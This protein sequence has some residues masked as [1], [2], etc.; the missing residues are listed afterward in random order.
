MQAIQAQKP[1]IEALR[2]FGFFCYNFDYSWSRSFKLKIY[3][4]VACVVLFILFIVNSVIYI[5]TFNE[6]L[7]DGSKVTF[8]CHILEACAYQ[9]NGCVIIYTVAF[10]S[11]D[12]IQ[13]LKIFESVVNGLENLPFGKDDIMRSYRSL[14]QNTW[15]QIIATVSI[16]SSFLVTY[17]WLLRNQSLSHIIQTFNCLILTMYFMFIIA[18]SVNLVMTMLSLFNALND[19]LRV[20]I[21]TPGFYQKEIKLIMELHQKLSNSIH[22]FNESF[23]LAVF[24]AVVFVSGISTTQSYFAYVIISLNLTNRSI[25]FV[26]LSVVGL[27]WCISYLIAIQWLGNTCDNVLESI[28]EA[29]K[30]LKASESQNKIFDGYLLYFVG[31]D[32]RFTA[33]GLFYID[34]AMTFKV[35]T[36]Y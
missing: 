6:F 23:G 19:N 5:D 12:Q 24:G 21:V 29:R 1:L 33:N 7:G 31:V 15:R 25:E 36:H 9:F 26:I 17:I 2:A 13:F 20:F 30:L 35:C 4:G 3:C 8:M 22:F 27:L 18:L 14:K 28:E 10:T 34:R 16:N 11:S 32:N